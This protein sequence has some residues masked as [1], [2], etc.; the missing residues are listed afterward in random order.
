MPDEIQEI[1]E[2]LR[3]VRRR[4][5]IHT[6]LGGW[7]RFATGAA[8]VLAMLLG[9]WQ[10]GLEGETKMLLVA[11]ALVLVVAV[12]ACA[13]R[14]FSV[15]RSDSA[16]A[17]LVE[18][19]WP[20]LED[21]LAT[22]VDLI[23]RPDAPGEAARLERLVVRDAAQRLRTIDVAAAVPANHLKRRGVAAAAASGALM[24]GLLL[25]GPV[26]GTAFPHSATAD[27]PN[28]ERATVRAPD[29][30]PRVIRIDLH[31]T[32]PPAL[33]LAPRSEANGGDIYAPVGAQ[34]RVRVHVDRD[35]VLGSLVLST[36][37]AIPL[38][39]ISHAAM[40]G[41]LEVNEE[42]TYRPVVVAAD[43]TASGE[44][45][46]YFIR[47][48]ADDPPQV[49][50]VT[51]AGDQ[52]VTPLQEVTV[53]ARAEDTVA[54][55]R[56]DLVY[57]V[58][59]GAE[60][61][62]PLA[63]TMGRRS[64][65]GRRT[66]H[67]EDL[68]VEPGDFISLYARARDA[69]G[70]RQRRAARSDIVFLE[71]RSFEES[72]QEASSQA[73]GGGAATSPIDDLIASQKDIIAAT[74]TLDRRAED[75]LG[76]D[77][78]LR[79]V[80][81]AQTELGAR[82]GALARG[83]AAGGSNT[84]SPGAGA[85]AQLDRASREMASAAAALGNRKTRE[86][87][88]HEMAALDALLASRL[89]PDMW[90]VRRAS[91]GGGGAGGERA[92]EDL[93][94]LFDRELRRSE[95]RYETPARGGQFAPPDERRDRDLD[96]VGELARRQ[97]A[98]GGELRKLAER[99]TQ[100]DE[101]E[102]RRELQ[103]LTREQAELRREA[104]EMRMAA[105]SDEMRQASSALRRGDA[106]GASAS[107]D[108]A[109]ANLRDA[110][111]KL[112]GWRAAAGGGKLGNLQMEALQ[113]AEAERRIAREAE[114]LGRREKAA[115]KQR[116]LAE[117]QEG[118]ARRAE[119]LQ[120]SLAD[121][122]RGRDL[123]ADQHEV[124]RRTARE[125]AEQKWGGRMRDEA[126]R[127]RSERASDGNQK[128]AAH[129]RL[130]ATEF[131]RLAG[132]IG[133]AS[134]ADAATRRLAARL[135]DARQ[136]RQRLQESARRVEELERQNAAGSGR[137]GRGSEGATGTAGGRTGGGSAAVRTGDGAGRAE[138]ELA[139]AREAYREE[140]RRASE[141]E[142]ALSRLAG[143]K[144]RTPEGPE[145]VNSAPGTEGFKQDYSDWDSLRRRLERSLEGIESR[146]AAQ[147]RARDA[148]ERLQ[149]GAQ[150][151]VFPDFRQLV[152]EY[153]RAIAQ[154]RK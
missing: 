64:V 38:V 55:E 148:R 27:V 65:E 69:G 133:A 102:A 147:I 17:R 140:L 70:G 86:A 103:R 93:S 87:L 132:R 108:R 146:L 95:T 57:S 109:L 115:D 143:G 12:A 11:G 113:L 14:G 110:E 71:V 105:A 28:P 126:A 98:L 117:E 153:Y 46:P 128:A 8:V 144:G 89:T 33:G 78:D 84:T 4:W 107:G 135:E 150:E 15:R 56:M 88:P 44:G 67:L 138:D 145:R 68:G 49:T 39:P 23:T 10:N 96:R 42:G 59:G 124:V 9:P 134:P 21:T 6:A 66:L 73:G 123:Q 13:F 152:D 141:I 139:K 31:Y 100:M 119:A 32:Y 53:T 136:T 104:E 101:L 22:A 81:R 82:V 72:F 48:L 16:V 63:G 61:S 129:L 85:G 26:L 77:E 45:T 50:L 112:Q 19:R 80:Q 35:V 2:A 114:S 97:Q 154:T 34:V 125:M 130:L 118:L 30:A 94:D 40:E 25:A 75:G 5:M 41:E 79:S 74:W 106:A 1:C 7:T 58:G 37:G 83:G 51:P 47:L 60:R 142:E 24:A 90:Q 36:G 127:M 122:S 131:E 137:E 111:R 29:A 54:V 149:A 151:K 76:I 52:K 43:G 18:Q 3:R 91:G 62:L 116:R 120:R 20:E 121:A 92:R 99:R